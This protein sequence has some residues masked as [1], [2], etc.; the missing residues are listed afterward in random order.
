[1]SHPSPRANLKRFKAGPWPQGRKEHEKRKRRGEMGGG[2]LLLSSP[3]VLRF[4]QHCFFTIMH[5]TAERIFPLTGGAVLEPYLLHTTGAV[6]LREHPP[7]RISRLVMEHSKRCLYRAIAS[8]LLH[9][10][11]R[12][13]QILVSSNCF[14]FFFFFGWDYWWRN[15][16]I[17]PWVC[18]F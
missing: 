7:K 8:P 15:F 17:N 6:K 16:I 10:W 5:G 4:S 2:P 14:F 11:R 3:L 12:V 13:M 1:M 18:S 9:E